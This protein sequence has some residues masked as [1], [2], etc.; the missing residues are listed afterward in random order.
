MK[1]KQTKRSRSAAGG[2]TSALTVLTIGHSTHA[3]EEFIAMLQAHDV[4]TVIDVRT[5]PKSR[6]NPQFVGDALDASLA[7]E[8]IAYL[9]QPAL[10][11]LRRARRD[12]VNGGWRNESF[13][14]FADYMQTP[15]FQAGLDELVDRATRKQT[16]IMCAEAVPW[17][18]HRQLISD[19]LVGW[20]PQ[21]R[22]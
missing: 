4:E 16:A 21:S 11:G 22:N 14:G 18:C 13:R 12:S 19:A 2:P 5:I 8:G 6:H 3:L 9:H 20:S 10:G 17:R 1:T 7:A 15:E